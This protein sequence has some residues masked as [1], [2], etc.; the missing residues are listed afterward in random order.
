M[1]RLVDFSA[2]RSNT[3]NGLLGLA[4]IVTLAVSTLLV[5]GVELADR[6]QLVLRQ[7]VLQCTWVS[8]IAA[9]AACLLSLYKQLLLKLS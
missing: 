2:F 8:A 4:A 9:I 1:P 3:I 7:L 6:S 5:L